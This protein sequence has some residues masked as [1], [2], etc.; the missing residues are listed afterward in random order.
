M[1]AFYLSFW[2]FATTP[3][4][5]LLLSFKF[6]FKVYNVPFHVEI[7]LQKPF[8]FFWNLLCS[9]LLWHVFV[10]SLCLHDI[11][12]MIYLSASSS[13]RR[14]A[15]IDGLL[16]AFIVVKLQS[17]TPFCSCIRFFS[18]SPLELS[19]QLTEFAVHDPWVMKNCSGYWD[20]KWTMK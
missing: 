19:K 15:V 4:Q 1:A 5:C 12:S 11:L 13:C 6:P 10:L 17:W 20:A 7:P 14:S 2:L 8:H 3:V 16:V 9:F 18:F